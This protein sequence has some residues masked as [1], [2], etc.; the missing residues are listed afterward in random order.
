MK[1]SE[2]IVCLRLLSQLMALNFRPT[3]SAVGGNGLFQ[4]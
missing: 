1:Y 4:D 2:A 3:G